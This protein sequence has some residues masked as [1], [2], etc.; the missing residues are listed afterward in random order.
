M[1]LLKINLLVSLLTLLFFGLSLT[2]CGGLFKKSKYYGNIKVN[3][4]ESKFMLF[5]RII[6]LSLIP[7]LNIFFLV[8]F[9]YMFLLAGDSWY[10]KNV[11]IKFE[12]E[13]IKE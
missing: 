9:G 3:K 2:R 1:I 11:L 5:L 10:E 13:L 12:K 6:I 8:L 7:L 4:K